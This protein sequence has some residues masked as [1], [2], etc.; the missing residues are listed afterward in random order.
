[1]RFAL[2]G[3]DLNALA[4]ARAVAAFPGHEFTCL[5]AGSQSETRLAGFGARLR[6]CR[7]WEEL[8]TDPD[9]DSVIV[10][11][12]GDDAQQAVRQLVAA[13]K[14]VL[15]P[16]ALTQPAPFF[17][18]LALLE[19]EN[20]GSL[21][22]LLGLRG[23]PLVLKLR[24]LI[25]HDGLGRMRHARLERKLAP[26]TTGAG[27]LFREDDLAAALLV[28]ADLLRTLCGA[29]DQVTALR[30]GDAEHGF[31]LA[32]VTLAGRSAPQAVWTAAAGGDNDWRL[33]LTGDRGT[34]VLE[35]D[36]SRAWFHLTV[37]RGGQQEIDETQSDAAFPWLVEQ[38][39]AA[40]A[41]PPMADSEVAN[42]EAP[43]R[44]S[45]W[46]ELARDVEL[47]D[48][49]ERSV[50]RRRTIDVFFDTPSERGIFK[51]QMTAVGC[52]LLVLT[53][54]AIVIY[55]ALAANI[56]I[57]PL[58]KRVLVALLFLPLGVF[59]VLQLLL[60]I[61]RPASREGR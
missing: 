13:G 45:F 21:F 56:A 48:A 61:S 4:A 43:P 9:V 11:G 55:L 42:S 24:D 54:A 8:L 3:A 20:P 51:T 37:D 44:H 49:V 52:C 22:P 16:P 32:T 38:F 5:V 58:V 60:F 40:A 27:P 41:R 25:I 50:R 26:S 33:T 34:A 47:V 17:Y 46:D 14:K 35:G 57:P 53:P 59:L 15:L 7:G 29:Y 1:M 31:S 19:A 39:S 23:H 10:T 12:A 18:E 2:V 28:D 30:S 6:Y 36:P